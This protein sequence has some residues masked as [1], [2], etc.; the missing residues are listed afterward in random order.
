MLKHINYVIVMSRGY[1]GLQYH[2]NAINNK[3]INR[4]FI[5][6][7]NH[8]MHVTTPFINKII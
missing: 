2:A 4:K 7:V 5:I 8:N 3:N 1:V 6:N